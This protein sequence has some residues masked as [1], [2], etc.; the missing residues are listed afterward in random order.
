MLAA[1]ARDAVHHLLLVALRTHL[2]ISF[3]NSPGC[4]DIYAACLVGGRCHNNTWSSFLF[5]H[6]FPQYYNKVK[7]IKKG[8]NDIPGVISNGFRMYNGVLDGAQN[9]VLP[10]S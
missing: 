7:S 10:V 2:S 9:D 1:C 5:R 8:E 4:D 6:L 3:S